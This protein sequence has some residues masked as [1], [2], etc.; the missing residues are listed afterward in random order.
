LEPARSVAIKIGATDESSAI[1]ALALELI[2]RG[3]NQYGRIEEGLDTIK[4]AM[5]I[6]QGREA[7]AWVDVR[8]E[9][10][11]AAG[12]TETGHYREAT[13]LLN[14]AA[15]TLHRSGDPHA[16]LPNDFLAVKAEL[17]LAQ[18]HADEAAQSIAA[19]RTVVPE[20]GAVSR[21]VLEQKVTEAEIFLA[22]GDAEKAAVQSVEVRALV[23]GS[24]NRPYL[25]I[26][27]ARAAL[28]EG[29]SLIR[30][31]QPADALPLLQGANQI[32]SN[33]FD[34]QRSPFLAGVKI[35][36]ANCLLDLGRTGQARTEAGDARRIQATH[37]ELGE[38]YRR[39][40]RELEAR[41]RYSAQLLKPMVR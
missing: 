22:R 21:T 10:Q 41:L 36:L 9:V 33:I 5:A 3:L 11:T 1:P 27:E 35:A 38:H 37:P 23:T 4:V 24:A 30:R 14:K 40:L 16:P 39:P 29:E 17:L 25:G 15:Q 6:R 12:L 2:A 8:L 31:K 18:G 13:E 20:S 34:P 28:V 7:V 26:W 32:S 19:F